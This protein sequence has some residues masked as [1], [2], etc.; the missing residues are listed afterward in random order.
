M[1]NEAWMAA[2]P[3]PDAAEITIPEPRPTSV[4]ALAGIR[5]GDQIFAVD[6]VS[7]ES[8]PQLLTSIGGHEMGSPVRLAVRRG[9][10]IR[11]VVI[12]RSADLGDDGTLPLD[13]EAPSGQVFYLD[14]ARDLQRRLR[15]RRTSSAPAQT[16]LAA[17]SVRETQVLRLV[18]DGATNPMIA[19]KLGIQRPT[20]ARHVANILLKLEAGNRV[21]AATIASAAGLRTDS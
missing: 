11:E 5:A 8:F 20:V 3:M 21:E 17:L 18:A 9:D 7:L 14:R 13:C 19:Q 1:I 15:G 10:A 6:D 12:S 4:A 16:G 2:K